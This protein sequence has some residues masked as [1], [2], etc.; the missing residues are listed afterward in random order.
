VRV[1][2]NLL[3][4]GCLW[5]HC[6]LSE[7]STPV[8]YSLDMVSLNLPCT[9]CTGSANHCT[10]YI[11][12]LYRD[13]SFLSHSFDWSF[14]PAAWLIPFPSSLCCDWSLFFIPVLLLVLSLNFYIVSDPL[15]HTLHAL[16]LA[17][18]QA[19]WWGT[20][21]SM[22]PITSLTD[23]RERNRSGSFY[24]PNRQTLYATSFR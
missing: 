12:M 11:C 21:Q 16:S 14:F 5:N 15:F 10:D 24:L 6:I 20:Q 22:S 7:I 23:R 17:P 18:F 4:F 19:Q 2:Q 1:L 8:W 3:I 9:N 13:W